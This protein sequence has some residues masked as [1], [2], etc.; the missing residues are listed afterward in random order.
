M[1]NTTLSRREFLKLA[2]SGI[3]GVFV[4]PGL[5]S[6]SYQTADW[7]SLTLEELPSRMRTILEL[8]PELR[9]DH[10]GRL[11][12]QGKDGQ[13]GGE[14]PLAPTEW[15]SSHSQPYHRLSGPHR[16]GIVLHW[17]GD[18]E[19]FDCTVKGYLRGFN[20]FREVDGLTFQTSA[21]FLVTAQ[22]AYSGEAQTGKLPGIVQTQAADPSDG[23][24]YLASHILPL[25]YEGHKRGKQYFV[26][27]LYQL[28]S[29][30]PGL[31]SLLQDLFEGPQ[32]DTNFHTIAIEMAGYNF[33]H[34]QYSPPEQQLANALAVIWAVMRRYSIRAC[35]IMGHHELSLGKPDPGKKTLALF[36]HLVGIKALVDPDPRMKELVFRPFAGP[37]QNL[38]AGVRK[39]F[40][41]TRDYLSLIAP[42]GSVYE[43]EASSQYWMVY[44]LLVY[45]AERLPAMDGLVFPTS[46]LALHGQNFMDPE[47][48]A[49]VDL[50]LNQGETRGGQV[51]DPVPLLGQGRCLY[52]GESRE[53]CG[54]KTAAFRHRQ[55]DG[56]E[57]VSIYSNLSELQELE[58]GHLYPAG[59]LVGRPGST[60][61][62]GTP[63]LHLA[64]TYPSAWEQD[65]HGS[66]SLPRNAGRTWI[67]QRF[68]NPVTYL[69]GMAQGLLAIKPG[70][71][72]G[73]KLRGMR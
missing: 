42:H 48:H 13:P 20:S 73:D 28:S 5:R 25:D 70:T 19:S 47:E 7:P 54:R 59:Y 10:T 43:W 23:T 39:Y 53:L 40:S 14:M 64:I 62:F 69:N 60:Y 32:S 49:G 57:V 18:K 15:N 33:E 50:Y 66:P 1:H 61:T 11:V 56:A 37:E 24:P 58:V 63:Y 45:P 71:A 6:L 9:I 22:A 36:R 21:H 44:D 52:L 72:A 51:A 38:D 35:D 30:Y 3:L 17:Y 41:F 46:S 4:P 67:A 29:R 65:L 12:M 26:R 8:M 16:W 2:G 34:P 55:P 27:A 68:V 31:N